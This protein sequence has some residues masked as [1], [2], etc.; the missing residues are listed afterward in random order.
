MSTKDTHPLISIFMPTYNHE[1]FIAQAIDSVL[2][3]DYSNWELIIGDD[4]SIDKTYVIIEQYEKKYPEKIKP[5]RN[6]INL[7]ITKNFNK[8]LSKCSGK[9]IAIA[10]GDDILL[11]NKLSSQ[12]KLMESNINCILSYHDIE[13]F[14]STSEQTIRFWNSGESCTKPVTG[15]SKEVAKALVKD[16][17]K[18]MAA[19]S[20]MV[21][22]ESIPTHGHDER[23]P[24]ASD[25][26]L[27]IEI[28]ANNNGE[29]A[30]LDEIYA[31]Y[32]KHPNSITSKPENYM[33]DIF[34]TLALVEARYHYLTKFAQQRRAHIYYRRAKLEIHNNNFAIARSLLRE[35][36]RHSGLSW[37]TT[38]WWINSLFKQF[39]NNLRL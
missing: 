33:E 23:I 8:I 3:Q 30:F 14:D 27:W 25:W 10:S 28:C 1:H 38:R 36:I 35:H 39:T 18:F 19:M 11:P 37:K 20:V 9:Y 17:T 26:L 34:V 7:G 4:A 12:V 2:A 24:I 5:F 29:V 15:N 22:K 6:E 13:V 31:R 16:G 21:K 32:R